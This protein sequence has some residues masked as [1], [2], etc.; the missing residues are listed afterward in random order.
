MLVDVDAFVLGKVGGRFFV[1]NIFIWL[2][3]GMV[4]LTEAAVNVI[5][6]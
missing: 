6:P 2:V 5:K 4:C 3:T 1:D